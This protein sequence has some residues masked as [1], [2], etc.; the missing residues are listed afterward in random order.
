MV[1]HLSCHLVLLL[2]RR[3]PVSVHKRPLHRSVLLPES[4]NLLALEEEYQ[5]AKKKE[6]DK[7]GLNNDE[8][9][10]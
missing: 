4:E 1:P 3:S 6:L 9:N 10:S 5:A 2:F 8:K 7:D